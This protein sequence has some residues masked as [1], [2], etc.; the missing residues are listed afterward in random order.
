MFGDVNYARQET[1]HDH[2]PVQVFVA[3]FPGTSAIV[4]VIEHR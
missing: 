4:A 2:T 3:A 1:H